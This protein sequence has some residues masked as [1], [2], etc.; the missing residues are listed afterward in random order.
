[1]NNIPKKYYLV[2]VVYVRLV[3]LFGLVYRCKALI[4]QCIAWLIF[5]ILSLCFE[6]AQIMV[7]LCYEGPLEST[8]FE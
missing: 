4:K 6:K 2:Y 5:F 3:L 8:F 7:L 1:M